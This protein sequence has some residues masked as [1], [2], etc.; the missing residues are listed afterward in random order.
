LPKKIVAFV[1]VF[2][3]KDQIN[4][5]LL[6]KFDQNLAESNKKSN[7]TSLMFCQQAAICILSCF[8]ENRVFVF[9]KE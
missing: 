4:Y 9:Q 6:P 7:Q 1:Y 2:L 5:V 3:A 8:K